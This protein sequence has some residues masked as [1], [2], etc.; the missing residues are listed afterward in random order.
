MHAL[1]GE[2]WRQ[3][4]LC[5]YNLEVAVSLS[6]YVPWADDAVHRCLSSVCLGR[7]VKYLRRLPLDTIVHASSGR[8]LHCHLNRYRGGCDDGDGGLHSPGPQHA[9][10]HLTSQHLLSPCMQYPHHPSSC[11]QTRKMRRT[12]RQ[13]LRHT[14]CDN[15]QNRRRAA[16]C[17][18]TLYESSGVQMEG[19]ACGLGEYDPSVHVSDR[20]R[21]EMLR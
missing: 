17:T 20:G 10:K 21:R 16:T 15:A 2:L 18:E 9:D 1:E 3:S 12:P 14:G 5:F 6:V 19:G 7:E 11:S 8:A 13:S 4:H